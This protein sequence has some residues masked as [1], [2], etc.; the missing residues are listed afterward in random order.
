M[1]EQAKKKICFIS[2]L[3]HPPSP[4]FEHFS[5][6]VSDYGYDVTMLTILD[7]GQKTFEIANGRKIYRISVPHRLNT[8]RSVFYFITRAIRFLN[9][10]DFSIIHIHSNCKYFILFKMLTSNNVKF[11]FHILSHPLS[12]SRFQSLK[13]MLVV[14]IQCLFMDKII[15]QSKELKE[16][17]M[18]LRNL[19]KAVIIPVG[20]NSKAFYPIS[21]NEKRKLR[22]VL[23]I[24]ENHQILIYCGA[25]SKLR[26]LDRLL[27]A[28]RRVLKAFP[29]VKLLMIGDGEALEDLKEY[30]FTLG[31][32]KSIIFTGRLPHHDVVNYIGIADIGISYIPINEN[33]N[34]NPPLKTF[35]YMACGL[36]TIATNTESNRRIIKDGFNGILVNDIPDHIA[37]AIVNLLK[38]KKKQLLLMENARK[39]IMDYD[40][41]H[42]TKSALVPLYRRL[43]RTN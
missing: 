4:V 42:I 10:Y 12:V 26:Q 25:I 2:Y 15:V 21:K 3:K 40:F 17:W 33:Y 20:F 34:Y 31:I 27:E 8:K 11:V 43:L 16:H 32:S 1:D 22:D 41:G 23:N 5:Q 9:K 38:D 19:K 6:A 28:F 30:A 36:P 18:G 29:D 13:K 7:K 39:S 35:E 14:S 24:D 37:T